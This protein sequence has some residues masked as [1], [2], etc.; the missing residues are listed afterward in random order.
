[1]RF[2]NEN[3]PTKMT[4]T[5]L[6]LELLKLRIEK[7]LIFQMY[8]EHDLVQVMEFDDDSKVLFHEAEFVNFNGESKLLSLIYRVK[9]YKK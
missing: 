5:E 2:A 1:M 9:N 4:T 8:P 3:T 6:Q 7:K